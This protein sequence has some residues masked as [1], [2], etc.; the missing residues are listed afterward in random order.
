MF[1]IQVIRLTKDQHAAI[2]AQGQITA[3][4]V[5]M[6]SPGAQ[7]PGTPRFP[8]NQP[9]QRPG[10][11]LQRPGVPQH[12]PGVPQ[13][14][15]GVPQQRPG[16]PQQ[17][18]GVPQQRPGVP[19]HRPGGPIGQQRHIRPGMAQ[20]GPNVGPGLV[21]N[22]GLNRKARTLLTVNTSANVNQ[23]QPMT[24]GVV[25][26]ARGR[27]A[28]AQ[29]GGT[30]GRG[31]NVTLISPTTSPTGT[32][33]GSGRGRVVTPVQS[34][35]NRQVMPPGARVMTN[36]VEAALGRGGPNR[37]RGGATAGRGGVIRGRGGVIAG[38]GGAIAGRGGAIAG[39]GGAIA[40]RGGAIAGRGQVVP[41]SPENNPPKATL[42]RGVNLRGRVRVV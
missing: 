37:G 3:G 22:Q 27:G 17:R 15:P 34:Q 40:G 20:Q 26:N 16:V 10:F 28:I 21:V 30:L 19:Q 33:P 25:A 31:G 11:P 23:G 29:R 8:S 38:R 4:Q 2:V 6:R 7:Q 32:V 35:S 5:Q 36:P 14:R 18:P 12:R 41:K 9:Q 42:G 1:S 13:Q 39:R 24:R